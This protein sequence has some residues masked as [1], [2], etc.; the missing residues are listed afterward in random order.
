MLPKLVL[1]DFDGT[2][3]DGFPGIAEA[4]NAVRMS[5]GHEP[6]ELEHVKQYVGWGL[7]H[8]IKKIVP[9]A[10][11]DVDI[12]LYRQHYAGTM[13]TGTELLPGAAPVVQTLH[14]RGVRLGVCSNKKRIYTE[15]L[16]EHLGIMPPI[17]KVFG[18]D[19]VPRHKPAPD[20]L[21]AAL[22]YFQVS[23]SETIYVGDMIVDIHCAHAAGVPIWA[24]PTGAMTAEQLSAE[25][26]TKLLKNMSEMLSLLKI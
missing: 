6:V 1:F 7:D 21:L 3:A 26:P 19:D 18:P 10:D 25:R 17:K 14:Q 9:D 13:L 5:R 2:L 15:Q 20:M 16:L 23:A 4:V 12:P 22:K 11:L 24:I 8:L